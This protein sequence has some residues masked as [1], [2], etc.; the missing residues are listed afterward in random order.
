[1]GLVVDPGA[2][3]KGRGSEKERIAIPPEEKKERV[4]RAKEQK[5]KERRRMSDP[6]ERRSSNGGLMSDPKSEAKQ[7]KG[8]K[9][10]WKGT[11]EQRTQRALE[12]EDKGTEAEAREETR[13]IERLL[14]IA[15]PF[16]PLLTKPPSFPGSSCLE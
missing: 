4:R 2:E 15:I 16:M 13:A 10:V 9:R 8:S 12:L 6:Q 7:A 1:M 5:E 14:Y 11:D 3:T